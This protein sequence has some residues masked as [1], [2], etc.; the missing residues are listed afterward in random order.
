MCYDR[1]NEVV[2][3]PKSFYDL[4]LKPLIDM[5][6]AERVRSRLKV[7][8]VQPNEDAEPKEVKK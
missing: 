7:Y 6:A 8:G 5:K 1:P 4:V 2:D 3:D